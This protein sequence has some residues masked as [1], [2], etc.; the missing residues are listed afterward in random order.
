MIREGLASKCGKNSG[1][2]YG[3]NIFGQIRIHDE[4]NHPTETVG[5][6]VNWFLTPGLLVSLCFFPE[7]EPSSGGWG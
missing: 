5:S 1:S 4:S 6:S 3:D 7:D 2:N